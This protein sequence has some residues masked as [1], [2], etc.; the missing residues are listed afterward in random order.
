[1]AQSEN[2]RGSEFS[3]PL[4]YFRSR[5]GKDED[6]QKYINEKSQHKAVWPLKGYIDSFLPAKVNNIDIGDIYYLVIDDFLL[7]RF[8]NTYGEAEHMKMLR[9]L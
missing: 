3:H 2:S 1:M 8:F 6:I 5:G 7:C 9:N 4:T